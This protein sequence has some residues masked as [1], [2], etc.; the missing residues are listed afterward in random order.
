MKQLQSILE[1]YI[2]CL[3]SISEMQ[4]MVNC[5]KGFSYLGFKSQF[6]VRTL[7][8]MYNGEVIEAKK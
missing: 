3:I 4:E 2:N 8:A 5:I 6:G 7:K 1:M